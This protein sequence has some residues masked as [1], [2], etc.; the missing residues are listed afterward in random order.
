[1][2]M[3]YNYTKGYKAKMKIKSNK[4]HSKPLIAVAILFLIALLAFLAYFFIYKDKDAPKPSETN[5]IS[6]QDNPTTGDSNKDTNISSNDIPKENIPDSVNQS[7]LPA[8][9]TLVENEK[10]KIRKLSSDY[11][12]TLYAIIN[13]PSQYEAYKSQLKEYKTEALKYMST[14]KIDTTK[15]K[16]NYEPQEAADL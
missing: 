7:D 5:Q 2:H 3:F 12:I 10:F 6:T 13:S 9:T 1:M 4:N 8:Y 16:I 11:T 14:Q 15:V